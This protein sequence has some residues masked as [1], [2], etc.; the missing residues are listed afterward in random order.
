MA[1][2]SNAIGVAE[3]RAELSNRSRASQGFP[4]GTTLDWRRLTQIQGLS[5]RQ[6]VINKLTT[7]FRQGQIASSFF[8]LV[9]GWALIV[10]SVIL[11]FT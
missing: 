2:S 5:L 8:V 1:E 9:D 6:S 10:G 11:S 4:L 7:V 3:S